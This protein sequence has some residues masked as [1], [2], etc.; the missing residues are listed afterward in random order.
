MSA[1]VAAAKAGADVLLVDDNDL[2]GGSLNYARFD[3][4]GSLG[5]LRRDQLLA[6]LQ[7]APNMRVLNRAVTSGWFA[8]N[9]LAIFSDARLYKVRAQQVIFAVGSV[10]QPIV[11]R[12]ND[13]PGIMQGSAAQRLIR[14]YG[15]KPG[16]TAVV[17][18]G[19]DCGYGVALDLAEAGIDIAAIADLRP[20][21]A[22]GSMAAE[23]ARRNLPIKAVTRID[24]AFPDSTGLRV[25][26]CVLDGKRLSCDLICMSPGFSPAYQLPAQAGARVGYDDDA[27]S[28][29][30]DRLPGNVDLAGSVNGY[31]ALEF[32]CADGARAGV[33]AANNARF[34]TNSLLP[35]IPQDVLRNGINMSWPIFPHPKGKEFVDFD[36]DLQIQDII[37]T[38]REGYDHLELVKRFS[39]VGMGPSQGRQSALNTARLVARETG[40]S[41]GDV[42]ITTSRP[43]TFGEPLAL[44]AGQSFAPERLTPMHDQHLDRGAQMTAVGAWWRPAFYGTAA[45]RDSM[46]AEEVAAIRHG[47]GLI[48][49]STLGKIEIRGPDAAEFLDRIYTFTYARQPVGRIRYLLMTNEAGTVIDDGVAARLD[50]EHFYLT[51]TT[52]AVDN[53]FR[54]MQFWNAQWRLKIDI[55]NVSVGF[56]AINLAGP[57]SR[58]VLSG[59]TTD[60]DLS[61]ENFPYLAVR[62]G[63]LGGIPVRMLRIGFVGELGYEIHVPNQMAEALWDKLL[64]AGRASG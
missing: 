14:L 41:L 19:N 6:S 55:A 5:R 7:D 13:L 39:T 59:L 30:I 22:A 21:A 33:A 43:P 8:D 45:Q 38:T 58:E 56:A 63:S 52:G 35:E 10:E 23:A 20:D 46:V 25:G 3:R 26:G 37:D 64:A 18:T 62:Q 15:V 42:A 11:F 31:H 17:L 47:V 28:F 40:A 51:A 36:E 60:I 49:V 4:E 32:V 61:A 48:D 29:V 1:A 34:G 2:T 44:L 24:E 53:T 12:N 50:A 27:A 9:W 16:S 54:Q 57:R